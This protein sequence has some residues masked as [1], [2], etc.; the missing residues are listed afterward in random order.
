MC[1]DFV[2]QA[3]IE[4]ECQQLND[5]EIGV[6]FT[7]FLQNHSKYQEVKNG[8]S[9]FDSTGWALEDQ[10]VLDLFLNLANDLDIGL[11][12]SIEHVSEDAK[13]PYHFLL[14]GVEA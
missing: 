2:E 6:D 5:K 11:P 13:N 4:G 9:V 10:V 12:V 7:E 14:K 8:L 3:K 1:P